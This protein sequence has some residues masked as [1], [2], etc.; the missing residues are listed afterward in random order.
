MDT[1]IKRIADSSSKRSF[2]VTSNARIIMNQED[3][4][5]MRLW[6]DERGKLGPD[7]LPGD[8]IVQLGIDTANLNRTWCER[9]TER[10][11]SAHY[12]SFSCVSSPCE[13]ASLLPLRSPARI[14]FPPTRGRGASSRSQPPILRDASSRNPRWSTTPQTPPLQAEFGSCPVKPVRL[15]IVRESSRQQFL[16]T[17]KR[18]GPI[19]NF[20]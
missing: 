4:A 18:C 12:A 6:Q 9:S 13:H 8:L 15:D 1:R 5:L 3:N 10:P 16:L 17:T 19:N 2:I 11:Q 20:C 7:D 14:R